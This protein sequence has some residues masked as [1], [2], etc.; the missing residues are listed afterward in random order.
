[1]SRPCCGELGKLFRRLKIKTAR[2]LCDCVHEALSDMRSGVIC[3]LESKR[4]FCGVRRAW[5]WRNEMVCGFCGSHRKQG[6]ESCWVRRG[7][8]MFKQR[9]RIRALQAD[10]APLHILA[11]KTCH[12]TLHSFLRNYRC[13]SPSMRNT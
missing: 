8:Q 9:D 1:M 4:I 5:C 7:T 2:P 13:Q 11:R 10:S 6:R 3:V 12:N